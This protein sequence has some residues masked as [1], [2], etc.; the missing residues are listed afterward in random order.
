MKRYQ[1]F[2]WSDLLW[3]AGWLF[4]FWLFVLAGPH[5]HFKVFQ[6]VVTAWIVL[7]MMAAFFMIFLVRPSDMRDNGM[8][9]RVNAGREEASAYESELKEF[10]SKRRIFNFSLGRVVDERTKDRTNH[11][12]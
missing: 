12:P 10:R 5:V 9:D 6:F 8:I 4:G 1:W 2:Y 3:I 7:P 11:Q